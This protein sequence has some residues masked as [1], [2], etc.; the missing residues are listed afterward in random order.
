MLSALNE[1]ALLLGEIRPSEKVTLYVAVGDALPR[2]CVV[3]ALAGVVF[4]RRRAFAP[5]PPPTERSDEDARE[6]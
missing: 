5:P 2:L 1:P 6:T 4:Y 3:L